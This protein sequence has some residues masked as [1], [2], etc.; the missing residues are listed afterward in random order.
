MRDSLWRTVVALGTAQTLAYASTYY[1]P[2]LVAA[3]MARDLGVSRSLVLLAFSVALVVSA[4][5]G[6][7]AGRAIDRHGGQRV[8]PFTSLLFAAGLVALAAARGPV[9]L[10]AAW[11]LLGLAMGAG[12]YETAFAALVRLYGPRSRQA[13]TGITLIAGF[14]STV[15]WPLTAW[16]LTLWDWRGACLAWAALHLVL[17]W[18]L[19]ARLPRGQAPVAPP[20]A[21]HPSGTAAQ[22]PRPAAG[23]GAAVALAAVFAIAWFISTAMATHLPAMLQ[24]AGLGLAAAVAVG[25]LVGPAQVAGR[26]AEFGL[27]HRLPPIRSA[28][29]AAALHPLA[30]LALL[31]A[32]GPGLAA[33]AP[34][35]A[36]L[37]G[38][39][40][41][42]LTIAKG[43]LP[44]ALFGPAGYGARLGL[45][46]APARFAQ[47][48]APPLFGIALERWGLGALGL[49]AALGLVALV[50]LLGLGRRTRGHATAPR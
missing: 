35:F 25:T 1:L 27:M 18:P 12:L 29:L 16:W 8:L 26:L 45:I 6:P 40:V 46:M 11:T 19:N 41:G 30:A 43:S 36:L 13:I 33:A 47:A 5:I 22:E 9:S 24:A 37:H 42:I 15:G 48:L 28:Q 10:F 38:A 21:L 31:L 20:A 32:A 4:L 49:T 17:G 2:A 3:P 7:W 39:G 34:V 23:A 14:A 50:I 44:L